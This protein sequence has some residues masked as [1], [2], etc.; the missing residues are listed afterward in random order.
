MAEAPRQLV[1]AG[2][3][4]P[5]DPPH[6]V[7]VVTDPIVGKGVGVVDV[8]VN[9]G[10]EVGVNVATGV[11]VYVGVGVGG[12]PTPVVAHA[13]IC[14]RRISLGVGPSYVVSTPHWSA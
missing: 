4:A 1:L 12:P 10:V 7:P 9:V 5:P 14:V 2:H 13:S 11:A 3:A 8:G 6:E